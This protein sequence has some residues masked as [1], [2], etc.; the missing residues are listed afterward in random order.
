MKLLRAYLNGSW[1]DLPTPSPENYEFQSEWREKSFRDSNQ[2][3]HRDMESKIRKVNC[4]WSDLNENETALH[5]SLYDLQSFTLECT[6]NQNRRVQMKVY[7]G[8]ISA[9]AK[10][11]NKSTL[12]IT[13]RT[14]VSMNFIEF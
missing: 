14:D 12:A 10:F 4:G 7:A 2:Y 1:V 5:D 6:D 13:L 3:L 9:K 11:M 8:P